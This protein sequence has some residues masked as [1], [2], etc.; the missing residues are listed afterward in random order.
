MMGTALDTLRDL[1]PDFAK[2]RRERNKIR[3]RYRDSLNALNRDELV[4]T[5]SSRDYS[6]EYLGNR[7]ENK[8]S[9]AD[10]LIQKHGSQS[11]PL[12]YR[13]TSNKDEVE[14]AMEEVV[15][16]INFLN[17]LSLITE[18]VFIVFVVLCISL[19]GYLAIAGL[20]TISSHASGTASTSNT[21]ANI[22]F[23]A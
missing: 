20:D 19:A 5:I 8:S 23:P 14:E 11:N 18:I 22:E 2:A 4:Y 13:I 9:H 7:A 12:S 6:S 16:S 21:T 10:H 17:Y 1:L 3:K 15:T